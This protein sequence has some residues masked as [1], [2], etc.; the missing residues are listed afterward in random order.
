M[1]VWNP[2]VFVWN[3]NGGSFNPELVDRIGREQVTEA[4]VDKALRRSVAGYQR[5]DRSKA[6]EAAMNSP[7]RR[8][9]T[10]RNIAIGINAGSYQPQFYYR[11]IRTTTADLYRR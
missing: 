1:T 4:M 2:N 7:T 11:I 6:L 9:H 3:P 8:E 10:R 5:T